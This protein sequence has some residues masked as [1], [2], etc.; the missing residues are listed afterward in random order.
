MLS[1]RA[2]RQIGAHQAQSQ[3]GPGSSNQLDAAPASQSSHDEQWNRHHGDQKQRDRDSARSREI[4]CPPHPLETSWHD[5]S[6]I[7]LAIVNQT[8]LVITSVSPTNLNLFS[9][10]MWLQRTAARKHDRKIKAA[11]FLPVAAALTEESGTGTT[12]QFPSG[13]E[14][15]GWSPSPREVRVGRGAF[16]SSPLI[17]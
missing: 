12:K 10:H 4:H 16:R 15:R 14:H 7:C 11:V 2:G 5:G 1:F 9:C 13:C 8:P 3:D 6:R 17:G